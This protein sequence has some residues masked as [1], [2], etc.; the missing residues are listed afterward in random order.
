MPQNGQQS[1][2]LMHRLSEIHSALPGSFPFAPPATI[3]L[4]VAKPS[5][6][7]EDCFR[8]RQH[9]KET[10]S[11]RRSYDPGRLADVFG[12]L[13][14][15]YSLRSHLR[16]PRP[17]RIRRPRLFT[18]LYRRPGQTRR[19]CQIQGIACQNSIEIQAPD[20]QT[21]PSDDA[22]YEKACEISS[23]ILRDRSDSSGTMGRI[24]YASAVWSPALPGS[25]RNVSRVEEV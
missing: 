9:I 21:K 25:L 12:V 24:S 23:M 19:H 18:Q 16:L 14:A 22:C 6:P 1:L 7:R 15:P 20:P 11:K 2:T 5:T 8:P 17:T 4:V 3:G 10:T 13:P